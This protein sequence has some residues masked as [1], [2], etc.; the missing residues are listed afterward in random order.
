[1]CSWNIFT[2][3]FTF[4]LPQGFYLKKQLFK[5]FSFS[6]GVEDFPAVFFIFETQLS[7]QIV[8]SVKAVQWRQN[9][10]LV[11]LSTCWAICAS[12]NEK[13]SFVKLRTPECWTSEMVNCAPV[14]KESK[15]SK[16]LKLQASTSNNSKLSADLSFSLNCWI[17]AGSMLDL[18]V[19]LWTS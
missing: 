7:F 5:L 9:K 17:G 19:G 15:E 18:C 12:I 14:A 1:M 13:K 8:Q 3:T 2:H 16:K 6:I 4:T 11:S 10:S